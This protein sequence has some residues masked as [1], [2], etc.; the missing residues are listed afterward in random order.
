MFRFYYNFFNTII[1]IYV[2]VLGCTMFT[3][4]VPYLICIFNVIWQYALHGFSFQLLI[5]AILAIKNI[6]CLKRKQNYLLI[7]RDL[8]YFL[9]HI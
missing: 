6:I 4:F 2:L 9:L 5:Y 7:L 3:L 8:S 1:L